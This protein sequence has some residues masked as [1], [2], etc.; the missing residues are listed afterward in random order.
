M[1]RFTK[2]DK[3]GRYY[4]ESANGKLENDNHGYTYGAAIDRFAEL[5]NTCVAQQ[6]KI[7]DLK[8][9][10]MAVM[11]SV[12]KWL[13]GDELN[14]DEVN[15]AATM[16]EKTLRIIENTK[17]DTSEK[18]IKEFINKLHVELRAYGPRDKF[19]KTFFLTLVDEVAKESSSYS[20]VAT[21]NKNAEVDKFAAMLKEDLRGLIGTNY[22]DELVQKYK[23]ENAI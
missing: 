16:R 14:Q 2:Q 8:Y 17:T 1:E 4:I 12:D 7:D 22:I 21:N 11:H 10:L 13:E 15:R 19:N 18:V 23:N 9:T 5:E 3:N 6:K 20:R